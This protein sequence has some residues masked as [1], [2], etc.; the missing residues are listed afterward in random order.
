MRFSSDMLSDSAV[1]VIVS[2]ELVEW[3]L[4][5]VTTF[6]VRSLDKIAAGID[7]IR[8]AD[9]ITR[10]IILAWTLVIRGRIG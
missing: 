4:G 3:L 5:G 1:L 8:A 2:D 7:V 10:M 9:Q 6:G